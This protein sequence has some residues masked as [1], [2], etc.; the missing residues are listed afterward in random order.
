MILSSWGELHP[1]DFT[2]FKIFLDQFVN[3]YGGKVNNDK[4][5][6]YGW[7]ISGLLLQN[8]S[9]ILGFPC[10]PNWSSFKYLG[11]PITLGNQLW[12]FGKV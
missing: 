2:R 7:N 10:L 4:V 11:M 9:I 3:T 5:H 6:I 8:I 1:H 12:I